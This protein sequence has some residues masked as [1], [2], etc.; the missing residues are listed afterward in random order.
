MKKATFKK[1]AQAGVAVFGATASLLLILQTQRA[2]AGD[3][4]AEA[5]SSSTTVTSTA[6]PTEKIGKSGSQLWS[7]NC[8]RCHNMRSPSSYSDTEWDVVMHHMR[9]RANLTSEEHKK[10]LEFLKSAN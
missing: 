4:T 9:V 8:A 10:I 5:A 1:L 7:E 2:D 3:K 6:Q